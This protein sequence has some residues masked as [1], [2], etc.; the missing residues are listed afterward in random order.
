[1]LAVLA[2]PH[3]PALHFRSVGAVLRWAY[4]TGDEDL[5][6]ELERELDPRLREYVRAKYARDYEH[7]S[8]LRMWVL[9]G[10]PTGVH[11]GR[12]VEKMIL[13]H[14]G[15]RIGP[16]SLQRDLRCTTGAQLT[17]ELVNRYQNVTDERMEALQAEAERV[18]RPVMMSR[19]W[20]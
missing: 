8:L 19:G 13:H 17:L 16:K 1:V 11:K 10:L 20:L 5:I 15:H 6:A 3:T 4:N 12:G 9:A 2:L 7:L 14:L 18:L